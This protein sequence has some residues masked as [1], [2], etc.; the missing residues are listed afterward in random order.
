MNLPLLLL[1]IYLAGGQD[2]WLFRAC[3]G[4]VLAGHAR[5]L[6]RRRLRGRA[7]AAGLRYGAGWLQV[8]KS[9]T[10]QGRTHSV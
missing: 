4:G 8:R 2:R 10:G 6:G 1:P 7:A 5:R 3:G 9:C